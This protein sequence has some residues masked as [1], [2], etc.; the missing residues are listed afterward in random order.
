MNIGPLSSDLVVACAI[1]DYKVKGTDG[2]EVRQIE[3]ILDPLISKSTILRSLDTLDE[4]GVAK[5]I[6]TRTKAG[7]PGRLFSVSG[8]SEG[9]IKETYLEFWKYIQDRINQLRAEGEN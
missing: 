1:Y 4:W 2:V 8:E 7:R 9:M 6:Y 5:T 3:E